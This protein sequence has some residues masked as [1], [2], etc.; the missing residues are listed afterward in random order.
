MEESSTEI[1][2][3]KKSID[4]AIEMTYPYIKMMMYGEDIK[5]IFPS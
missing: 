4:L 5:N 3:I 1:K 2:F